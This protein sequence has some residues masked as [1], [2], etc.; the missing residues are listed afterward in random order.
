MN[1]GGE[2]FEADKRK[3]NFPQR[4]AKVRNLLLEE[5]KETRSQ[6][7]QKGIRKLQRQQVRQQRPKAAGGDFSSNI[8]GT[9]SVDAGGE[10]G[11]CP[12]SGQAPLL[13]ETEPQAR[14]LLWP[15]SCH[16]LVSADRGPWHKSPRDLRSP[17]EVVTP[18]VPPLDAR[19][20]PTSQQVSVAVELEQHKWNVI[21]D[22]VKSFM[23]IPV[24]GIFLVTSRGFLKTTAECSGSAGSG[25]LH[26]QARLI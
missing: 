22:G 19:G 21:Q 20:I 24:Y 3:F 6:Q 2:P 17:H 14:Y 25:A 9:T 13:P 23:K 1:L 16:A 7:G 8:P 12:R 5:A 18:L 15:E 4:E 11:G 10:E 26:D